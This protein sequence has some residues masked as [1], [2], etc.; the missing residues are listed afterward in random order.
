MMLTENDRQNFVEKGLLK[1]P[2]ILPK[3][4]V[5]RVRESI[6]SELARLNIW[7]SGRPSSA[8]GK[9]RD[10]P[11]FQQTGRLSQS[12]RPGPE[13]DSLFTRAHA[14]ACGIAGSRLKPSHPHPQLL[15][16]LPQKDAE[17]FD[18]LGWHLDLTPPKRNEAPGVQAFVLIDDVNPQGGATLALAGSHKLHYVEIGKNAHEILRE[19]AELASSPEKFL[20]PQIVRGVEIKIVE[21]SGRAGDMYLMDL[22]VLH[23]PSVNTSRNVRM[24]ATMRYLK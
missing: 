18:Q 12:V 14:E 11:V 13:L 10:F 16:S 2:G 20:K 6:L 22:R 19:N 17:P 1:L 4:V 15:I 9:I 21:M 24:M 23:S 7:V 5:S 8:A 3:S